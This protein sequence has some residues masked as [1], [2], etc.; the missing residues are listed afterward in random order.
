MEDPFVHYFHQAVSE[1]VDQAL[2]RLNRE[3]VEY[4][5][6]LKQKSS[7][8]KKLS[9]K[10]GNFQLLDSWETLQIQQLILE[11]DAIYQRAFQDFLYL[12]K[13]AG[14][15]LPEKGQTK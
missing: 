14:C 10:I 2:V 6:L 13:W 7:L 12:L 8:E 5:E 1:S 11:Q 15:P 4:R 3:N 9:K